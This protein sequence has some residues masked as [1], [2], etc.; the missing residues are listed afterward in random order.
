MN[1]ARDFAHWRMRTALIFHGAC[2]TVGLAG[3]IDDGIGL[4]DMR[5]RVL[6]WA[7]LAAQRM[8]CRTAIFV[9]LRIPLEIAT[10]KGIVLA[11]CFVPNRYVRLDLLLLDHPGKHRCGALRRVAHETARLKLETLLDPI[12]HRSG[13]IHLL[14]PVCR[15]RFDID[16]DARVQIDQIVG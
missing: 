12:D 5:A 15:R 6:E 2:R 9:R 11:F 7:P 3:A 4:G 8:T 16:N 1:T 13:R 14:S 10:R